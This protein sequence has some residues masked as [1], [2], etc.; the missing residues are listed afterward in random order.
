MSLVQQCLEGLGGYG[1]GYGLSAEEIAKYTIDD[2]AMLINMEA[3]LALDE[4]FNAEYAVEEAMLQ[5]VVESQQDGVPVEE[6]MSMG[7]IGAKIK[8]KISGA[9]GKTK[10]WFAKMKEKMKGWY[11]NTKR[12]F[13][14]MFSK[15]ADFVKRYQS[16]IES[17]NGSEIAA[18]IHIY[19][20]TNIDG[21]LKELGGTQTMLVDKFMNAIATGIA[22]VNTKDL[23]MTNDNRDNA[24]VVESIRKQVVDTLEKKYGTPEKRAS[25]LFAYFRNGAADE[26]GKIVPSSIDMKQQVK[27]VLDA[28]STIREIEALQKSVDNTYKKIISQ[29]EVWQHKYSGTGSKTGSEVTAILTKFTSGA[30]A[31]QVT[32]NDCTN[33]CIAAVKERSGVA[34]Q[35]CKKAMATKHKLDKAAAKN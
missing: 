8:E 24:E 23:D 16:D 3:A 17:V 21:Y 35:I 13:R 22:N 25:T 7:A 1:L 29:I 5:A 26:N 30:S 19:R 20:Y 15:P 9:W 18:S 31:I 12:V 6:K 28:N 11:E 4:V 34:F 14:S 2:G 27:Y 33:A 10:D 32:I